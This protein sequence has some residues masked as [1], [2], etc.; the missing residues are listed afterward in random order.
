MLGCIMED[1]PP[2]LR[3]TSFT[4][5]SYP[6]RR[7]CPEI[8]EEKASILGAALGAWVTVGKGDPELLT[9]GIY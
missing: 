1:L 4:L 7:L 8:P 3:L 2:R 9:K 6:W 5:P